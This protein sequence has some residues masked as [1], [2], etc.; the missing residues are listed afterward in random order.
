MTKTAT[1]N[2]ALAA[3][4][5]TEPDVAPP[6]SKARSGSLT[7]A[8]ADLRL[9]EE[10][11]ASRVYRVEPGTMIADLREVLVAEKERMRNNVTSCVAA[12][13]KRVPGAE[14]SIEVGEAYM[15]SGVYVLALITRKA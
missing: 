15:G 2:K 8:I 9:G 4:M 5:G 10:H 1:I 7:S 14:Y 11:P 12:A 6:S 13:K 3:A